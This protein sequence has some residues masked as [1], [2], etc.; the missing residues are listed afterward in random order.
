MGNLNFLVNRPVGNKNGRILILD[1]N[2][3]EIR[4]V[5][6]HIYNANTEVEQVQVL[7]ELSELMK[8]INFLEENRIVLVGDL[9]VFS[10]SK[11]ETKGGKPSL[12]QK[13]VAKLLELKEEYDLCDIWRIRNPI[14]KLYTFRQNPSSG[15]IDRRLDYIFISNKLQEFSNDTG[16]TPAFKIDHSSVLVTI[17]N[18]NFFKPGAG[19]WNI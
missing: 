1:V 7:S 6:V 8:N 4:Y 12:K 18:Y 5:L 15:I 16:I 9:N 17:S 10:D 13:S 14:K 19:L 11:L 2:I 3:D